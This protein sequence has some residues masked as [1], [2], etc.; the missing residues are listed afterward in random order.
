MVQMYTPTRYTTSINRYIVH[1]WR[2]LQTISQD[3]K[4]ADI[5]KV[6]PNAMKPSSFVGGGVEP[7]Q[8]VT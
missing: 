1:Q 2:Q 7:R 4:L 8:S 6:K 3:S 5:V